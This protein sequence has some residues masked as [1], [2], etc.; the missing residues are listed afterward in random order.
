M[1]EN[2]SIMNKICEAPIIPNSNL[3]TSIQ[4]Q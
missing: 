1:N 2:K 4:N 3:S